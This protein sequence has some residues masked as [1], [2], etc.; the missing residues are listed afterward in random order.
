MTRLALFAAAAFAL[1]GLALPSSAAASDW[2]IDGAH[3]H[4]GFKV[5]HMS[6]SWTRGE[7]GKVDGTITLDEKNLTKSSVDV[8]IDLGSV[9][10]EN[11]KRD[12]HLRSPDFFDTAQFPTMTFK[13]TKVS[14]AKNDAFTVT[15]DLT[16][17]GVTKS[18]TLDVEGGLT[19]VNDPW[20]NTKLGFTATTKIDRKDF[21]L[22][23]SKTLDGG[24]LV[25]GDEVRIEL[26]IELNQKK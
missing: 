11:A 12:E 21:G 24:G 17:H 15:G 26:E 9:D 14:K 8:T 18:V 5:R 1:A 4:V 19:P 23:W 3:S 25:V 6:V 16:L 20:G 2:V 13:S 10:T 22:T 7:F